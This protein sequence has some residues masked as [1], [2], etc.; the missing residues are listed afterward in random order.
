[1][2]VLQRGNADHGG[3]RRAQPPRTRT[4]HMHVFRLRPHCWYWDCPCG[5]GVHSTKRTLPDQ[6]SAL[7]A[8]LVHLVHQ[9][10]G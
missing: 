7:V 10:S 1:M 8:S 9:G 3:T 4:H 6:H 2:H 5:G